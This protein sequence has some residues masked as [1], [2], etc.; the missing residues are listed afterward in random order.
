MLYSPV[1]AQK[2]IRVQGCYASDSEIEGV[3]N[4]IKK[5][6]RSQYN[7][8]IEEKI[9]KITV[10]GMEADSSASNDSG[11]DLDDKIEE[12]IKI[13]IDAGQASKR[14]V[15]S[16]QKVGYARAGRMIDEMESLGIVGPHQGSKPRD[17]LMTYQ[18][19]LERK[20]ITGNGASTVENDE[21]GDDLSEE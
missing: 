4:Y 11:L 9:K 10:E 19:W 12:A 18:E 7:E 13:V 21:N 2:P 15:Q 3:T 1:G 14:F 8:E 16:R 6:Y 5:N 17:V 20:N